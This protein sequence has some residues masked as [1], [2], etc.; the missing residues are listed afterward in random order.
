MSAFILDVSELNDEQQISLLKCL[1]NFAI[2]E[3]P[4]DV[5]ITCYIS[6]KKKKL[7]INK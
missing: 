1:F 5:N 7:E 4:H 3:L 6:K 2:D